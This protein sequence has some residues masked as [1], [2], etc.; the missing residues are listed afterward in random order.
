MK[1]LNIL[2]FFSFFSFQALA[3]PTTCNQTP[4]QG[5]NTKEWMSGITLEQANKI[6]L[7][8]F[9]KFKI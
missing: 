1:F 7:S 3:N 8:E 9:D 6:I 2:L 4:A 5:S